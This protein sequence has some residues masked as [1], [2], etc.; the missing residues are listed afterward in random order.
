[1]LNLIQAFICCQLLICIFIGIPTAF[2]VLTIGNIF[3][4]IQFTLMHKQERG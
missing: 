4:F 1:M 2:V 3:N